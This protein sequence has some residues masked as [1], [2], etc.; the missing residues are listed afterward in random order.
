MIILKCVYSKGQNEMIDTLKKRYECDRQAWN[1]CAVTYERQIVGGHPDITAFES[2]E[3]DFLDCVIRYLAERQNRLIKL[4]DIG[5]GSGRLH[6]RY[7]AKTKKVI[8]LELENP[9]RLRKIHS[10]GLG[11]DP[12]IAEKLEEVWGIDFSENMI[13]MARDKLRKAG[14]DKGST[15]SLR[16]ATGSA[17]ELQEEPD[18]VLPVAVC[19][20]NSIGVMQGFDGA[21]EL[22]KSMRRAVESAKG[23]AIISCYQQEFIG[24]YGL[25]QYESTMDVSGQPIWMIPEKYASPN[26]IQVPKQYKLAYNESQECMV[27]VFT[28]QG[29]LIKKDHILIRDTDKAAHTIASG[30]INTYTNYKSHWYSFSKINEFI[31]N[32]WKPGSSFHVKTKQLD[33]VR[34]EPAQMAI[35][36]FG[37]LL[38]P[39]LKRWGVI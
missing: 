18:D 7:G 5:C 4:L 24:S 2:F 6:M 28:T 9:L 3:E 13:S 15:I 14:L 35:L 10:P 19:L 11:Y 31:N 25:G 23:I 27:D 32:L 21:N 1:E 26:F 30:D 8:D 16:F 34:A 38:G 39:L 22:F 29:D 36:D 33:A 20:V 37:S 12:H 17:F